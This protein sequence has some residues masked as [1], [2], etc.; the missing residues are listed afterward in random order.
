M[1]TCLKQTNKQTNKQTVPPAAKRYRWM[2]DTQRPT[3]CLAYLQRDTSMCKWWRDGR[4]R[5]EERFEYYG[6]R[7]DWR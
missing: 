7:W 1:K 2:E 5:E 6:E 4:E 3:C